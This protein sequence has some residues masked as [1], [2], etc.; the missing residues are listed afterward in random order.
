VAYLIEFI[1]LVFLGIIGIA[2]AVL[3]NWLRRPSWLPTWHIVTGICVLA[4]V[5]VLLTLAQDT[6][7]KST[8]SGGVAPG[9]PVSNPRDGEITSIPPHS[10]SVAELAAELV[11]AT[12]LSWDD[13]AGRP[14]LF[15]SRVGHTHRDLA[16]DIS[17][18]ADI[19]V[20]PGSTDLVVAMPVG[21]DADNRLELHSLDGKLLRV[22]TRPTHNESD[23]SPT[24]V[25]RD[26]RTVY[27]TRYYWKDSAG[28]SRF[29]WRYQLMQMSLDQPDDPHPVATTTEMFSVSAGSDGTT[30][31]GL[32][33]NDSGPPQICVVN[34][35]SGRIRVITTTT[36]AT[37]SDV[38]LSPGGHWIAY[39]S[40]EPNPYGEIEIYVVRVPQ[41]EDEQ[42]TQPSLLMTK[43]PGRNGFP[44]WAPILSHRCLAFDHYERAKG[45]SIRLACLDRPGVTAE[46]LPIGQHPI[47][48]RPAARPS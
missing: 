4:L 44:A 34:P 6:D 39:S 27:F 36:L 1:L 35:S 14:M 29:T 20:I 43:L 28:G 37:A 2:T 22:L 31:A 45:S 10:A 8:R 33:R 32:C 48:L 41:P 15:T 16:W 19:G 12:L 13:S 40:P 38:Q 17:T 5:A 9:A 18:G 46:L 21:P 25:V 23:I 24:V 7:A 11:D 42:R 47:W 26:S 3:A 30:L